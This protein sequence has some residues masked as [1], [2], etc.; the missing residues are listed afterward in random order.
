MLSY[1][2]F[3]K[4]YLKRRPGLK[5]FFTHIRKKNLVG[6]SLKVFYSYENLPIFFVHFLNSPFF[7]HFLNFVN[8]YSFK[9]ICI[10]KRQRF[11]GSSILLRSVDT[12]SLVDRQVF[13]FSPKFITL[14]A[15]IK[16]PAGSFI[17]HN[18]FF[19]KKLY[20]LKAKQNKKLL[21]KL[22]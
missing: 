11:F 16:T 13:I 20:F 5:K 15:I 3:F 10:A 1:Q 18:K 2:N 17:S 9:G 8:T 14:K 22:Y 6:R 4:L 19:K 7:V 21:A 12:G